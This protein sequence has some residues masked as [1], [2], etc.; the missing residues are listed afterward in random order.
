[1]TGGNH[2]NESYEKEISLLSLNLR[3]LLDPEPLVP[4]TH[5]VTSR[6]LGDIDGSDMISSYATSR[7]SST[8][9]PA[10]MNEWG[11]TSIFILEVACVGGCLCFNPSSS[12]T[13]HFVLNSERGTSSRNS[14]MTG[15]NH[16]NES[17]AVI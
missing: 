15:R 8:M 13:T 14:I 3:I 5:L 9:T 6:R 10:K 1:M 17:L 4:K 16:L 12:W 7:S 11:R 2:L